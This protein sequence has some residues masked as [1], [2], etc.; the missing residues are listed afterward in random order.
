MCP[1]DAGHENQ[2]DGNFTHSTW[3]VRHVQLS[4][5]NLC[6]ANASLIVILIVVGKKSGIHSNRSISHD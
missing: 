3:T 2:N 6:M 5:D 4:I 1:E